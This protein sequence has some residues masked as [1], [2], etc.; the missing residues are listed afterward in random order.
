MHLFD[1]ERQLYV[2]FNDEKGNRMVVKTFIMSR[3]KGCTLNNLLISL[4]QMENLYN[5]FLFVILN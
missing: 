4:D 1:E 2:C 5:L 3:M